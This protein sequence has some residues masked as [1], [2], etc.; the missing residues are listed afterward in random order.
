MSCK[1]GW[2]NTNLTYEVNISI[3]LCDITTLCNKVSQ[4][5]ATGRWF[6]PGTPVFSTNKTDDRHDIAEI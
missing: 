4:W 2:S 3:P 6:P 1:Y 5:L